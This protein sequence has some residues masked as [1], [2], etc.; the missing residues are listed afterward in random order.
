M[1]RGW[2]VQKV[3]NQLDFLKDLKKNR[4]DDK[5]QLELRKKLKL[6]NPG[7]LLS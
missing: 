4:P 3:E 6:E 7:N 1:A 2:I 5:E